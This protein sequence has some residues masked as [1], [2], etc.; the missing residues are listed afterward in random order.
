[1]RGRFSK[2]EP[3]RLLPAGGFGVHACRRPHVL[4]VMWGPVSRM[5]ANR[6]AVNRGRRDVPLDTCDTGSG[7]P[8]GTVRQIRSTRA[9]ACS[10][11]PS[12]LRAG[13]VLRETRTGPQMARQSESADD[14]PE[15]GALNAAISEAVVRLMAL[16][17]GRGPTKA[18]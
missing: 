15:G 10:S 18:P 3:A 1:M 17:T 13:Q 2:P 6:T 8:C 5:G 14:R 12:F 9:A 4:R 7:S 11:P 16:R